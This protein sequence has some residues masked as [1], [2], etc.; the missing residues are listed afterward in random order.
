MASPP[1]FDRALLLR[2]AD[3]ARLHVPAERQSYLLE[4]MRR[5][6]DAF[7]ALRTVEEPSPIAGSRATPAPLRPDQAEPALAL[8]QVLANA[9]Q[10]AAG[11][12][13]VPRVVDG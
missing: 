10:T 13:V 1:A 6:V 4:S 2:L 8:D 12:F 7:D 5:V 3:L 11:M 9:G